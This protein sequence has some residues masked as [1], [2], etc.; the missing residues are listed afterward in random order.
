MKRTNDI[1]VAA[2]ETQMQISQATGADNTFEE[3]TDGVRTCR[4]LA[5]MNWHSRD[6]RIMLVESSHHYVLDGVL[7]IDLSVTGVVSLFFPEFD[8][9]A[10]VSMYF[11]KWAIDERSKYFDIIKAGR[12]AG[13]KDREIK[14][15]IIATWANLGSVAS[16]T[17]TYIHRQIELALNDKEHDAQ[18][19]E[20]H[21]FRDFMSTFVAP[22][23]WQ[24]YRT[25]WAIFD[26]QFHVAG[27]ID[28]VF[29]VQDRDEYHMVDWQIIEKD[30][31]ELENVRFKRYGRGPCSNMLDNKY[32]RFVAQ[33]NLYATI[34]Q[35]CYHI[36][37]CTMWLVQIHQ[38]REFFTC[39]RIPKMTDL[40]IEMLQRI[41][42]DTKSEDA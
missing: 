20:L 24:P 36:D 4:D 29:K 25:E 21:Q 31:H 28:C 38:R 2:L 7:T 6:R 14:D 5:A 41:K 19:K 12:D 23:K 3:D 34:L 1:G 35:R 42:S 40:A 18:S 9:E 26:E 30:V 16:S 15:K 13:Y 39:L 10:V 22:R 17:G 33:Q 11:E 8:A 32:N 37:I 27:Q